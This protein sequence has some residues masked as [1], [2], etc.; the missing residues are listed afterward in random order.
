VLVTHAVQLSSKVRA[1]RRESGILRAT[2]QSPLSAG[3]GVGATAALQVG[4]EI[5]IGGVRGDRIARYPV[6]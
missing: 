6:Q 4:K 3:T 5:W 1:T 2:P